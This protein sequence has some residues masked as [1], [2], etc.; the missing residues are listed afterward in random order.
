MECLIKLF[1][2]C[3]FDP[4]T[5]SVTAEAHKV[6]QHEFYVGRWCQNHYCDSMGTLKV[7]FSAPLTKA[8]TLSYGLMH[9]SEMGYSRD[10]GEESIYLGATVRPF[11][12]YVHVDTEV[13]V[14]VHTSYMEGR[15][16][17]DHWCRGPMGV[18]HVGL[19]PEIISGV[20]LDLGYRYQIDVTDLSGFADRSFYAGLTWRPLR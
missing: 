6:E 18:I 1:A 7:G 14:A 3:L 15:Y 8:L 10:H 4:S 16:C 12:N 5:V 20:R 17:D 13:Q 19:D 11:N 2:L 9:Q